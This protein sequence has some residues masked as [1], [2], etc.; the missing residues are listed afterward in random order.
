MKIA[1]VGAGWA[2]LASALALTK[3]GHEVTVFEASPTPGGRA[4]GVADEH[5]GMLDN[6]QHLLLGAYSACLD[7]ITQLNPGVK[8]S[9]LFERIP[10]HLESANGWF[11][12][13]TPNLPAGLNVFAGLWSARGLSLRDKWAATRLVI[14]LRRLNWQ[15]EA[16]QTVEALLSLYRQPDQLTQR[17]W[18]PLCLAALNTSI[19]QASAQLFLNVLRDSLGGQKN[20]SDLI[21]PKVDLSTLWPAAA[22][23]RVQM[24][25][26]HLV[27]AISV[28]SKHVDIDSERFDAC[29]AAIPPYALARTLVTDA[30]PYASTTLKQ[31]LLAFRYN[32]IATVTLKLEQAWRLPQ[33][34]LLLD[35]DPAQGHFGQW[36]FNRSLYPDQLTVVISASDDHL[37]TDRDNFIAAIAQQISSQLK[38]RPDQTLPMPQVIA[39]K[40]IIEK[41]ATFV[42][43][44]NLFRPSVQTPWPRLLI[45]GD[46]TD[47]DYPAVLEGAVRSGLAAAKHLLSVN[48]M[49]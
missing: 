14:G 42:A 28:S 21:I 20:H 25:Y 23:S 29:V 32:A 37:R 27:R 43:Q 46:Y 49:L 2:G 48:F 6:G 35:E 15:T 26:R 41:R 38:H 30:D 8:Q 47:T 40:L 44:P 11:C 22:A 3:A 33:P 24:R 19:D 12:L 31:A 17:L 16:N 18:I 7:L 9:D 36:V 34:L 45:A 39:H 1:V 5:L 13:R 10:L 4:R